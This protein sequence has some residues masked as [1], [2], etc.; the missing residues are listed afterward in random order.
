MATITIANVDKSFGDN[1]VLLD[2]DVAIRDG[3]FLTLVGPSGCGKSTLLKIIAGL[4]HQDGGSVLIHDK[5]IDEVAPKDRD[6]AMVR[7][8][9]AFLM[10]DPLSLDFDD[11][12]ALLFDA[13]GKRVPFDRADDSVTQRTA[14]GV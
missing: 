14:A 11:S 4:E 8:P 5:G 2:I 10:D 12:A 7:K 13:T 1:A 3:E 9:V 6:L